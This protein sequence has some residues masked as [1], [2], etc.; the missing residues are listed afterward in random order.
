MLRLTRG[1]TLIAVYYVSAVTLY[2]RAHFYSRAHL[3][4]RRWGPFRCPRAAC[5]WWRGQGAG[6]RG[7]SGCTPGRRRLQRL[8][9]P[10]LVSAPVCA[11]LSPRHVWEAATHVVAAR[12]PYA[13][14][15]R[16]RA[17]EDQALD[18]VLGV[19]VGDAPAA[20]RSCSRT[21]G[22]TSERREELRRLRRANVQRAPRRRP[23]QHQGEHRG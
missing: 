3:R 20:S 10:R 21:P 23:I 16:A 6:P 8:L 9:P 15:H 7:M 17:D 2:R 5:T 13:P 14:R 12:V 1:D 18:R 11:G 22:C 4:P 19:V